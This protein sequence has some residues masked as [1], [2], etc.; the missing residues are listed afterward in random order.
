MFYFLSESSTIPK[1]FQ[2]FINSLIHLFISRKLYS[3]LCNYYL[4][5]PNEVPAFLKVG[6]K[7]RIHGRC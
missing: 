2:K 4:V 1:F 6:V 5:V 7:D 3:I